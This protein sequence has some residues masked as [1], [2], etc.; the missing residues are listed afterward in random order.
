[1]SAAVW[2]YPRHLRHRNLMTAGARK[3]LLQSAWYSP[4]SPFGVLPTVVSDVTKV[5]G[6]TGQLGLD[7]SK[8]EV[9]QQ[10]MKR[11]YGDLCN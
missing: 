3:T 1:V 6:Q 9:H 5:G 7:N 11:S 10:E 8:K 2:N 4:G